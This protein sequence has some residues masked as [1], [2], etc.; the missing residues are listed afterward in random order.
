MKMA[1]LIAA[2]DKKSSGSDHLTA[3]VNRVANLLEDYL[4]ARSGKDDRT[5]TT[6]SEAVGE[7]S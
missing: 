1:G 2:A 7:K 5:T 3:M 4:D 6:T